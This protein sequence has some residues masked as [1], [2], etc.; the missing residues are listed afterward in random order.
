[1]WGVFMWNFIAQQSPFECYE[2]YEFALSLTQVVIAFKWEELGHSFSAPPNMHYTWSRSVSLKDP[3]LEIPCYLPISWGA[4]CHTH[5]EP[6]MRINDDPSFRLVS[7]YRG[8]KNK[9]ICWNRTRE[10]ST[11]PSFTSLSPGSYA[12]AGKGEMSIFGFF[13]LQVEQYVY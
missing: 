4:K 13:Y 10:Q 5:L 2:C 11:N 3:C 7:V 6:K 1:M 12:Y 9:T 8:K